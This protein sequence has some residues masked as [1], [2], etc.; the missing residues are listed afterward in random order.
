MAASSTYRG[1]GHDVVAVRCHRCARPAEVYADLEEDV[2]DGIYT[3][4][5]GSRYSCGW[6][7]REHHEGYELEVVS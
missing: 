3:V 4:P 1:P 2:Q 5:A 6:C 7:G